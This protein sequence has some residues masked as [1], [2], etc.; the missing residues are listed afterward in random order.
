MPRL[1]RCT[2]IL[3]HALLIA[4]AP[5]KVV[6][7]TAA[8]ATEPTS[9]V[10]SGPTPG[11]A[12]G[13]P[14][15]AS[16]PA[17]PES[18][19]DPAP[20]AA[21]E[22]AEQASPAATAEATPATPPPGFTPI[23]KKRKGG[24][25][26]VAFAEVRAYVFDL[27]NSGRPTCGMPLAEDG[28][29]CKTVRPSGVV[30]SDAQ[31][32]LLLGMLAKKSTWGEGS[33]CFLPHHGFVFYDEAGTPVAQISVCFMCQ[34][35]VSAPSIPKAKTLGGDDTYGLHE[36]STAQLR[37]LCNELGLPMCDAKSPDE[38]D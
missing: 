32:K 38:F 29:L 15:P 36:K 19:D 2:A 37:A 30:L 16:E 12:S 24:F 28:T 35:M 11:T 21:V 22:S 17:T 13:S 31:T 4:C 3:A 33:A 27:G 14:A 20:V 10:A 18:A 6:E 5:A 1:A 34:M 25:P 8:P 9:G 7:P 23:P 26:G